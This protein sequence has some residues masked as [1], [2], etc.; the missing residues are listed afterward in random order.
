[1]TAPLLTTGDLGDLGPCAAVR[2]ALDGRGLTPPPTGRERPAAYLSPMALR[3][4]GTR[5]AVD[6]L[7]NAIHADPAAPWTVDGMAK[8]AAYDR[9]HLARVFWRHTGQS[10]PPLIGAGG[11]TPRA[12]LIAVRMEL[13]KRLLAGTD[14][15][16]DDIALRV[17]YQNANGFSGRFRLEVGVHPTGYRRR[18][19]S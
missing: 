19:R 18:V 15:T 10:H 1:M 13:A 2:V 6:A 5:D 17:G 7:I 8:D 3:F 4:Q 14:L 11:L 16:L 9:Y 12:Y